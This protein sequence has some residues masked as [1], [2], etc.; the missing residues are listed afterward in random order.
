MVLKKLPTL[1]IVGASIGVLAACSATPDQVVT[2]S[3]ENAHAM[4]GQLEA[5]QKQEM[6][7]QDAFEADLAADESLANFAESGTGATRENL[8][9]RQA[10]FDELKSF[11]EDFQGQ[12][13]SLNEFDETDFTAEEDFANFDA[14]RQLAASINMQMSAYIENYQAVLEKEDAYYTSLAAEDSDSAAF[15]DGLAE[16]NGNFETSQTALSE[17]LPD[18]TALAKLSQTEN[19]S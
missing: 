5:I 4:M 3:S 13:E 7:L 19:Q 12:V 18:L 6:A 9:T 16:I 11:F 8:Q 17:M 1:A 15:S 2:K 10:E 14:S